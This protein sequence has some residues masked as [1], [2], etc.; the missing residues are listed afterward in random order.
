LKC[1]WKKQH[2]LDLL[3]EKQI[4]QIQFC[5]YFFSI[6]KHWEDN[7]Q[8]NETQDF[9]ETIIYA[10]GDV[11]IKII[12]YK[13]KLL[14]NLGLIYASPATVGGKTRTTQQKTRST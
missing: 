8:A 7:G 2:N 6:D 1:L 12:G 10:F 11:S 5:L 4:I 3:N 13:Q 14:H 9:D